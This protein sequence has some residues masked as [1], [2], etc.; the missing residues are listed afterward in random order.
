MIAATFFIGMTSTNAATLYGDLNADG[1]INS[2]DLTIMKRVLL[3]QRNVDDITAVD[4]N[5]DG[6]VTSTDYMLLKKYLLNEIIKFPVE[7]M[8][9]TVEPTPTVEVTPTPTETDEEEFAFRIKIFT[10]GETY[11]FPLDYSYSNCNVLVDWGDGTISE[12]TDYSTGKHKYENPGIYTIKVLSFNYVPHIRFSNDKNVIEVLT[13]FPDMGVSNFS[14]WFSGCNNL[15]KVPEG[16]FSNNV[17][18]TTFYWTFSECYN[19]IEIPEGLFKGNIKA[20][21]F[22]QCFFNCKSLKEIPERLFK[23]NI[24]ATVFFGC[25]DG[26]ESLTKIPERLFAN[27]VNATD[28]GGVF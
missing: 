17:N 28:F 20:K 15:M 12:I 2:T 7:D 26:R 27:N 5:G 9:P 10:D 25:F 8:Q 14:N 4:L 21:E 1:S 16:L 13:P 22:L 11:K 18:A 23:D 6:K 19:L 24:N 3:K